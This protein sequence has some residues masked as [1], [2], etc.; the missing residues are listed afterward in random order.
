M[1]DIEGGRAYM[2]DDVI[3]WGSNVKEHDRRLG[4]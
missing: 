3:V 1:D 4:R 2:D